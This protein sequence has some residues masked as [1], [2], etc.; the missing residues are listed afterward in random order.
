MK[1]IYLKGLLSAI[2]VASIL[3]GFS[4]VK[5]GPVRFDQ[6]V[7]TI[8]ARPGRTQSGAFTRLG[9]AGDYNYLIADDDDGKKKSDTAPQDGRVITTTTT[10]IV[11]DDV[12]DC[13]QP[14]VHG[15]FPYWYLLGLAAIP[16]GYLIV[17]HHDD[18]PT[19]TPTPTGTPTGTP[20]STPTGTPTGTPTATP[21][22]T[23]TPT[24]TSTPTGT[25]TRTPTSTPTPVITPTPTPP[26]PVPEPMTILLF[27]TGLASIGLAARRKFGKKGEKSNEKDE[28]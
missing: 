20:T 19:P 3:A 4:P 7:Q 14:D 28:E 17:H 25:P 26:E 11:K 18:T 9:V 23:V 16:V 12:C 6:V 22:G 21:T 27:G 10:D 1:N 2:C 15:G 13:V 8:N 24:P 5:A